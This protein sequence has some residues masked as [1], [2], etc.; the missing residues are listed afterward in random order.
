M[1]DVQ[2]VKRSRSRHRRPIDP[3]RAM[4]RSRAATVQHPSRTYGVTYVK[5][6]FTYLP[7]ERRARRTRNDAHTHINPNFSSR[8]QMATE[9]NALA[10]DGE[11]ATLRKLR[12][13]K[14]QLQKAARLGNARI[15]E[16]A[17]IGKCKTASTVL[18]FP[19]AFENASRLETVT[20]L[21]KCHE[22]RKCKTEFAILLFPVAF[23]NITGI[24]ETGIRNWEMQTC[25]KSAG[26]TDLSPL[27]SLWYI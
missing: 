5:I 4:D 21:K 11:I 25:G 3:S 13:R 26:L 23:E 16:N 9:Q 27:F 8:A 20:R 18:H 19:G 22:V 15:L 14:L 1:K 2:Y 10:Q 24:C 12:D 7:I 6:G 17:R